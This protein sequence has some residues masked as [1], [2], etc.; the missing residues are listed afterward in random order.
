SSKLSLQGVQSSRKTASLATMESVNRRRLV[1]LQTLRTRDF[2]ELAQA[3]PQ[4]DLRF[5]QLGRGPFR[6]HLQFLHLAGIQVF[7]LGVN[8]MVHIDG[9]PPPDSFGCCPA[10]AEEFATMRL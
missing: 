6:G 8:R 1:L 5:R 2:D 4:W 10:L 7:Q 3:F 9:W